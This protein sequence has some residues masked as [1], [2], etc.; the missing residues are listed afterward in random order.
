MSETTYTLQQVR[1]ISDAVMNNAFQSISARY[2]LNC[3]QRYFRQGE[4]N[5]S[6]HITHT[7]EDVSGLFTAKMYGKSICASVTRSDE[8]YFEPI[9]TFSGDVG[10]DEGHLL[11][12]ISE[13]SDFFTDDGSL[14]L[15]YAAN[16]LESVHIT[17]DPTFLV[18][19]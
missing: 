18:G 19:G 15:I 10:I 9:F 13:I 12:F 14:D 6:L 7:E 3:F 8:N 1:A 5:T 17:G 11:G 2:Y 4:F 16:N